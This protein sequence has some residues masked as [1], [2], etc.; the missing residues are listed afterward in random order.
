M[1][2][3]ARQQ[4]VELMIRQYKRTGVYLDFKD[5]ATLR[6]AERTLNR[7][8]TQRWGWSTGGNDREA[9]ALRRVAEVCKRNGLEFYH[10]S[11]PRGASLYIGKSD[12]NEQNYSS[13]VSCFVGQ[14]VSI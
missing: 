2:L 13:H 8:G 10:Q 5:I 14:T 1:R 6:R 9:G 3:T 11:D 4:N 12:I 7:W